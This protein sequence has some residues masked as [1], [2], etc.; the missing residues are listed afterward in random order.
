METNSFGRVSRNYAFTQ[1]FHARKLDEILVLCAVK[2][3]AVLY[4][5]F[6][7]KYQLM[8]SVKSVPIQSISGP[9]FPEFGLNA[10][11]FR[12]WEYSVRIRENTDQKNSE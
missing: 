10:K 7:V 3:A 12:I 8:H 6:L 9:Y 5:D 2:V 1:T 11:R 4:F